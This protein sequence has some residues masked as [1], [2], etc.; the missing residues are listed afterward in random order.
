MTTDTSAHGTAAASGDG[1]RPVLTRARRL[2]RMPYR[3]LRSAARRAQ[4]ALGARY[5]RWAMVH[6][7]LATLYYLVRG[8]LDRECRAVL[9]GQL[10][11]RAPDHAHSR[12]AASFTL[13]RNVHRLEKGLTM[14]PRRPS[15][16]AEYVEETLTALTMVWGGGAQA[17]RDRRLD[18]PL[19]GWACDVLDEYFAGV[20][21]GDRRIARCRREYR[22]WTSRH[23][24]AAA[25]TVPRRVPY[26]RGAADPPVSFERMLALARRRR[27]VRWYRPV[28]VP[29][30]RVAEALEIA[31]LSPSACNRQPFVFRIFDDP[32][33]AREVCGIAMGTKGYAEN[34]P[35]VAVV[36]GRQRAYFSARDRHLIY[37]DGALAAMSFMF[38]LETVGLASC[39]INWP[40]IEKLEARMAARLQLA[41]DERPIMLI[42]FGYADPDGG[43]PYS[44]KKR[45]EEVALF[46][47]GG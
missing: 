9:S 2:L 36:V 23:R 20:A 4:A 45:I 27:S 5:V 29:R 37:I 28:P 22:D 12:D 11:H 40:D 16:A 13:R 24:S 35:A 30:G 10:A 32:A 18:A 8:E 17:A 38:G 39:P 31:L 43:V 7:R 33:T 25:P 15:F 26:A 6:P 3:A 21:D 14:R 46:D 44:E 1:L 47:T 19:L 41:P 42:A 34:V